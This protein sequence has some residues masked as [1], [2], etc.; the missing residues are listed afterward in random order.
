MR[1]VHYSATQ[2]DSIWRIW[3]GIIR[4]FSASHALALRLFKRDLNAEYRRTILGIFW[5]FIPPLLTSGL[6]IFLRSNN[7]ISFGAT[8]VPYPLFVLTGTMLWQIFNEAINA[9]LA[10]VGANKNLLLKINIPREGL[11]FS[12]LYM[13]LF[14]LTVKMIIIA[15]AFFI[16]GQGISIRILLFPVGVASII[17]CGFSL[18]LLLVPIGMLYGDL[19]RI[20]IAV[21]PFLMYL[22]PVI[23]PP[24]KNGFLGVLTSL[25]PMAILLNTTRDALTD[26]PLTSLNEFLLINVVVLLLTFLGMAIYKISMP[27]IIERIGS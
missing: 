19:R 25:N 11:L 9:P 3:S 26:Q 14:N 13:L 15:L 8:S 10:S 17:L 2:R 21:L 7:V 22:T 4:S 20:L 27:L 1:K 24:V 6:W 5:A 16:F 18:G 12:G 23:Y